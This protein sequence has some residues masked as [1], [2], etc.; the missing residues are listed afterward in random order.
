[1]LIC[2][3]QHELGFDLISQVLTCGPELAVAAAKNWAVA[4]TDKDK[5]KCY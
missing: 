1:M 5:S 4:G 2:M 3:H